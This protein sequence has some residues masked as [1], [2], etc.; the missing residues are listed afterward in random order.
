MDLDRQPPGTGKFQLARGLVPLSDGRKALQRAR[1]QQP[2]MV[3]GSKTSWTRPKSH[4]AP[5]SK[6]LLSELRHRGI[7]GRVA[8][9]SAPGA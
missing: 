7:L 6:P 9:P 8:R 3:T 2:V 1:Y 5:H 4:Q